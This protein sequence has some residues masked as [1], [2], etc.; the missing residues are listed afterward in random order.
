MDLQSLLSGKKP[1]FTK[2]SNIYTNPLGLPFLTA[3]CASHPV[4]QNSL[5][6]FPGTLR[7]VK[8]SVLRSG[9]CLCC[10][11]SS[12]KHLSW[13]LLWSSERQVRVFQSLALG[14]QIYP[15]GWKKQGRWWW[16]ATTIWVC[17]NSNTCPPSKRKIQLWLPNGLFLVWDS[18]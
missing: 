10:Q 8:L 18:F 16:K 11:G 12:R 7:E 6:S 17:K 15:L 9:I 1:S 4:W 13:A 3:M 14:W 2:P 5:G